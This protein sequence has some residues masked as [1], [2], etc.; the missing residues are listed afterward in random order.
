VL[1]DSGASE[2]LI[3][4]GSWKTLETR[5]F[6]L[7]ELI[8]IYNLDETEIKQGKITQ[9]CWL[10]VKQGDKEHLLRF[11]ITSMGKDCFIL[12][13]PFLFIFNPGRQILGPAI[14]I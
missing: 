7:S 6:I 1:L 12:S 4:E 3:N 9:Y 8:I 2:N 14:N 10:N 5:A 13:Y 11:F